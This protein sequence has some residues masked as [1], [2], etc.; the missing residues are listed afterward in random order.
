MLL[1][2]SPSAGAVMAVVGGVTST[3]TPTSVQALATVRLSSLPAPHRSTAALYI[4]FAAVAKLVLDVQ[5]VVSA[6]YQT[7][8]ALSAPSARGR[9]PGAASS[10][11]IGSPGLRWCAP[12]LAIR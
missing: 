9:G 4:S 12:P 10:A 11:S 2:V 5:R 7:V 6:R 8:A 3:G 1:T